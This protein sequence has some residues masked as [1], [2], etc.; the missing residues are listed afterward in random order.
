MMLAAALLP[1]CDLDEVEVKSDKGGAYQTES[2]S[3]GTR[4]MTA[5]DGSKVTIQRDGTIIKPDGSKMQVK[6]DGT[7]IMPNGARVRVFPDGSRST[8]T[9]ERTEFRADGA[10]VVVADDGSKTSSPPTAPCP[11]S[12]PTAPSRSSAIE[13]PPDPATAPPGTCTSDGART[14]PDAAR[15]RRQEVVNTTA[16]GPRRTVSV[17]SSRIARARG[18]AHHTAAAIDA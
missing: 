4:V 16:A 1:A 11:A 2:Q 9:I 15:R 7:V 17:W 6:R 13:K 3:R 18:P 14:H 10:T 5:A 8:L 12:S